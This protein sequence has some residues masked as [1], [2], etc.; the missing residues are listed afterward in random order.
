MK[1]RYEYELWN[2]KEVVG[3][4]YADWPMALAAGDFLEIPE[5]SMFKQKYGC[6]VKTVRFNLRYR[7]IE[8][9]RDITSRLCIDVR[10]KSK[11]QID[12]LK[13]YYLCTKK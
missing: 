7:T 12:L 9:Y 8:C 1:M 3:K 5:V 2:G 10:R 13:R 6:K 4:V 11:R